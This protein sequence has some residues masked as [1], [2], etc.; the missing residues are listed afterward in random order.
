MMTISLKSAVNLFA[1]SEILFF[2]YPVTDLVRKNY[3]QTYIWI[4]HGYAYP[5]T[6]VKAWQDKIIP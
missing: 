1:F 2:R 6:A 5:L 4:Q 3:I